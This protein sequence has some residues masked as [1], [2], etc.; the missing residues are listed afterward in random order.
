M[1]GKD[2]SKADIDAYLGGFGTG[3]CFGCNQ[4]VNPWDCNKFGKVGRNNCTVDETNAQTF[5]SMW[6]TRCACQMFQRASTSC[7]SVGRASR[8]H[9]FGRH[10]LIS[11]LLSLPWCRLIRLSGWMSGPTF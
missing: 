4:E 10:A 5:P 3:A 9:K 11:Q 6:L 8:R 2:K 7:H 1:G